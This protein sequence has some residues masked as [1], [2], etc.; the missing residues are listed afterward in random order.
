MPTSVKEP[1]VTIA[2]PTYNSADRYL[3]LAIRSA[4]AQTYENLDIIVSDNG[5]IDNTSDVVAGFGDPRI[6][7][8]RHEKGL[9]PNGNFNF[10]LNEAKGAYTLLLH[11]DD[12]ID[13][14]YVATCLKSAGYSTSH[15]FVRT[16]ARIIDG[17]GNVI[18]ENRN[19][20]EERTPEALYRAWFNHKTEVYYCST[21]FNTSALR[22]IGGFR[23]PYNQLQDGYAIAT[24]A[25]RRDWVDVQDVK[26]SFR[27][28]PGQLTYSVPVKEW[29]GD[30]AGLLEIMCEQLDGDVE[31]FR[32]RGNHFFGR[33][34]RDRAQK[35]ATRF[36]RMKAGI[37]VARHFGPQYFPWGRL[38]ILGRPFLRKPAPTSL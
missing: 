13:A 3:P 20:V 35:R 4:L 15:S 8:I 28:S 32:E 17:E 6:R 36:G 25:P 30:F 31:E 38:R 11:D 21:L 18:R 1:L 19:V 16:G 12:L 10:C 5:S 37:I 27:K 24:L 23:S 2:I 7:Y 29:C 14:D 33:L 22:E 9:G 34:A 26:A